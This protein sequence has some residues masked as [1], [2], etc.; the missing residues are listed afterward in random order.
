MNKKQHLERIKQKCK[1]LLAI[2][3]NRAKGK[4]NTGSEA[5]IASKE[6]IADIVCERTYMH[7]SAELWYG[8]AAFIA[9]CAENSEAGWRAT[10][11]AIDFIDD[12][13]PDEGSILSDNIIAVWPEEIL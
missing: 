13:G 5:I 9:S 8:N 3:E 2:A 10:I 6:K 12:L 11:A 4:W 7:A 1:E